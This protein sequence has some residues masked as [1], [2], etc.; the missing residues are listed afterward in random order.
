MKKF[1]KI[2]LLFAISILTLGLV[3]YSQSEVYKVSRAINY[4]KLLKK[5]DN[6]ELTRREIQLRIS[7]YLNVEAKE[8]YKKYSQEEKKALSIELLKKMDENLTL[9]KLKKQF[10]FDAEFEKYKSK[11]ET[12]HIEYYLL[13]EKSKEV[14]KNL[15]SI[16]DSYNSSIYSFEVAKDKMSIDAFSYIIDEIPDKNALPYIKYVYKNELQKELT[17]IHLKEAKKSIDNISNNKSASLNSDIDSLEKLLKLSEVLDIPYD[18]VTYSNIVNIKNDLNNL[19]KK[20]AE[21]KE[22]EEAKEERER[23][24]ARKER[25]RERARKEQERE[26]A[27]KEESERRAGK[28]I[29]ESNGYNVW[30]AYLSPGTYSLI[31]NHKGDGNCIVYA[32]TKELQKQDLLIN[33]IGA[34]KFAATFRINTSG[35]YTLTFKTDSAFNFEYKLF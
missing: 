19:C 5:L 22:Q 21:L 32:G 28:W 8:K 26:Q 35:Y 31:V 14:G 30:E 24:Q 7:Q 15:L 34:G 9:D 12:F 23:E 2:I 29:L 11:G 18:K 25:E 10:N 4:K 1:K 33:K 20:N 16:T 27:M 17:E 6:G 3:S 13:T